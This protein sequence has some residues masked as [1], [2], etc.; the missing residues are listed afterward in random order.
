MARIKQR[1]TKKD[2][3]SREL[4]TGLL[5]VLVFVLAY[6]IILSSE[7]KPGINR[8]TASY[9]SFNNNDTTDMLKITDLKKMSNSNGLSFR[10]NSYKKFKVDG[11]KGTNFKIVLYHIGNVI[12]EK[13]VHYALFI[14]GVKKENNVLSNEVTIDNGGIVIYDGVVKKDT[15]CTLKMWVDNSY[16]S[17]VKNVSYEVRIK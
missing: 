11:E 14:D 16:K 3:I 2:V 5:V 9:I 13:Y 10:N 17:N 1:Y 4:F 6:F 8:L 12:D 7:L 15:N